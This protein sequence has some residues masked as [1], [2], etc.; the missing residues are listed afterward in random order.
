MGKRTSSLPIETSTTWD[1]AGYDCDHCGGRILRRTD[2]ETG[3][4]DRTCYQCEQCS[5]QWTLERRPLRV[6]TTPACRAAQ[7]QRAAEAEESGALYSRWLLIALGA[8][9]VLGLL[10]FG[11]G[12]FVRGLLPLLLVGLAAVAVWYVARRNRF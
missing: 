12:A 5:C 9:V 6:G 4:R 2:R 8:V 7:R 10:R 3:L 11:G 1:D